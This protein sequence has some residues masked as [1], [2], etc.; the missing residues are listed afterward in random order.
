MYDIRFQ[1]Y[2]DDLRVCSELSKGCN[3]QA[4]ELKSTRNLLSTSS[5][6]KLLTSALQIL[7]ARIFM[8]KKSKTFN[9][10][11]AGG[12]PPP[13]TFLDTCS[14]VLTIGSQWAFYT[15][16]LSPQAKCL[17]CLICAQMPLKSICHILSFP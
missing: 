10:I 4:L 15:Y 5:K 2:K 6:Q 9:P 17:E 8:S 7:N 16:C 11:P 12:V 13:I 3:L 14:S 1:R